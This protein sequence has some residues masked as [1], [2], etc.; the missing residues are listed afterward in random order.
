M[1][2]LN[3][4]WLIFP[5]ALWIITRRWSLESAICLYLESS[6]KLRILI[7]I[8]FF[9]ILW[10]FSLTFR[11]HLFCLGHLETMLLLCT[12]QPKRLM[13]WTRLS[14]KFLTLWRLQ[15]EALHFPSSQ[16]TRQCV[17]KQESRLSMKF[18]AKLNFQILQ[19]TF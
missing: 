11:C 13:H 2:T 3:C 4:K 18:V 7:I 14:L 8:F 9:C 16:R 1:H 17:L 15:R 10:W 19:G 12:L 5:K 6:T